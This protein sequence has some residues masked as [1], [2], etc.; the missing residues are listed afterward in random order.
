VFNITVHFIDDGMP[1]RS[2]GCELGNRVF[3]ICDFTSFTKRV[4][5]KSVIVR[6]PENRD[7]EGRQYSVIFGWFDIST[8]RIQYR[9]IDRRPVSG[10]VFVELRQSD[11]ITLFFYV[12]FKLFRQRR[13]KLRPVHMSCSF[14]RTRAKE[15]SCIFGADFFD[16]LFDKAFYV[17]LHVDNAPNKSADIPGSDCTE[18]SLGP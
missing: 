5:N 9:L 1:L 6:R 4:L 14:G 16:K 3:Y 12:K 7:V 10:L 18:A 2:R 13:K 17:F 8:Q 11:K 15:Y